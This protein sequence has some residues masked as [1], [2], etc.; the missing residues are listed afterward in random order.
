MTVHS[1]TAP[2]GVELH[3]RVD[4]FTDPGEDAPTVVLAHGFTRNS[5]MW[6]AWARALVGRCRVVRVDLRG[7]GL[8][9]VHPGHD[10]DPV[11]VLTCDAL[12]LLDEVGT[13]PVVWIGE[14]TG[15]IIG[16]SLAARCPRR[17]RALV[18]MTL[19]LV[20]HSAHTSAALQGDLADNEPVLGTAG[21]YYMLSH[22]M[23]AWAERSAQGRPWP[24]A[25][26]AAYRAW[27]V[28]QIAANDPVYLYAFHRPME[29]LDVHDLVSEIDVPAL[30]IDGDRDSILAVEDVSWLSERT[31]VTRVVLDGPGIDIGYANPEGAIEEIRKF[32]PTV[33][34][35]G[36]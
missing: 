11:S 30:Y 26:P 28:D 16:A 1:F 12:A 27:W 31:Q 7:H 15:A 20:T 18:T 25:A 9:R 17:L 21:D 5:R 13:G 3:Y 10:D 34:G 6:Y 22:G 19:P 35:S 2:G 32:D 4:D 24:R 33:L 36:R 14:A 8:S 29:N 23:R